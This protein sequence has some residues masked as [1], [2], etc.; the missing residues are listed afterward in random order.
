MEHFRSR[1][2]KNELQAR[3]AVRPPGGVPDESRIRAKGKFPPCPDA[4][5]MLDLRGNI[6]VE[7]KQARL[8]ELRLSNP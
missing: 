5:I 6:V 7:R 4:H 1:D 3:S 8:V 2:F